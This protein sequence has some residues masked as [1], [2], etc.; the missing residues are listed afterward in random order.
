MVSQACTVGDVSTRRFTGTPHSVAK[1]PTLDRI[2]VSALHSGLALM[3]CLF[4]RPE[5]VHVESKWHP[6]ADR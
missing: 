5:R 3:M 6:I 1:S 4:C 2:F